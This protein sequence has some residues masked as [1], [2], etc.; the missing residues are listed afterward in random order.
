MSEEILKA[1]MQLFAIIAK[2][3]DG[4]EPY[5][6]NYVSQFLTKQVRQEDAHNYLTLFDSFTEDQKKKKKTGN[7]S[8]EKE[9]LTSVRDS[10]KILGLCKRINKT[11][12]HRQK[13][14]VLVR[15]FELINAGRKFTKQRMAIIN[16]VS[17]V[18]NIA[19]D[20]YEDIRTFVIETTSEDLDIPSIL[21]INSNKESPKAG[22]TYLC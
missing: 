2:Q 10:V 15:L 14:I 20:E 8:K 1:L 3:D 12:D 9:K 11:L 13:V 4:V 18:F 5:E 17:E 19:K 7:V 16:T 22:Q 6:R 21:L